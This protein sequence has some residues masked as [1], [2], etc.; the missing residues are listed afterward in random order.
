MWCRLCNE[1]WETPEHLTFFCPRL[2]QSREDTF[3]VREGWP[4]KWTPNQ[5]F[6]FIVNSKCEELLID[7][8]DYNVYP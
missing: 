3:Q 5:V 1:A 4:E 7:E 8:T 6:H 2:R